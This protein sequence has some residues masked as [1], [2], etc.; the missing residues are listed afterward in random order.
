MVLNRLSKKEAE[1]RLS[2]LRRAVSLQVFTLRF[3]D[4]ACRE[5]RQT[6][7]ELAETTSRLAVEIHDVWESGDLLRKY[8]IDSPAALVIAARG[9]P[10]LRIYGAPLCYA[11]PALLD[12]LL[13]VAQPPEPRKD[14][15][16][17]FASSG[18]K[19]DAASRSI[20]V[21]L[22]CSRRDFSTVEALAALVR[23]A[24]AALACEDAPSLLVSVRIA[25]DFPLW[26]ARSSVLPALLIDSEKALSWPFTDTDIA[27]RIIEV[28]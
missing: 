2:K 12:A 9:A 11:F 5:V 1:T 16:E 3:E 25:E 17:V 18:S 8:R 20:A 4:A 10:E 27:T 21:D 6:A 14:L 23:S 22:V 28:L 26:A 7:E 24:G 13:A 15:L 19:P